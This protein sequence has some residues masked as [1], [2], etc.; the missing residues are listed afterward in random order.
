MVVSIVYFHAFLKRSYKVQI[1]RKEF[2]SMIQKC[3]FENEYW[4]TFEFSGKAA[5]INRVAQISVRNQSH[6]SVPTDT[7]YPQMGNK[8]N[9]L[10]LSTG[11]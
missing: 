6:L 3:R 9:L 11:H 8:I 10:Y 2:T 7:I 4:Q 1:I 5:W